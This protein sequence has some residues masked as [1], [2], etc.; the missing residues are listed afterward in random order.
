MELVSPPEALHL[1]ITQGVAAGLPRYRK[2]SICVMT[3]LMP[4]ELIRPIGT[5]ESRGSDDES[6]ARCIDQ[7]EHSIISSG[8]F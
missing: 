8:S 4:N 2:T 1:P 3:F 6:S 5:S 7:A